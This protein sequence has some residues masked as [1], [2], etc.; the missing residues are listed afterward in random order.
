MYAV[1]QQLHVDDVQHKLQASALRHLNYYCTVLMRT[2][3]HLNPGTNCLMHLW[4][5][6]IIIILLE[7]KTWCSN[8]DVDSSNKE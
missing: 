3:K 8:Q 7:V 2:L 4:Y 1:Q 5:N 6:S